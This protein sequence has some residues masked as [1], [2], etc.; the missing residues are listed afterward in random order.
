MAPINGVILAE[1]VLMQRHGF[2]LVEVMVALVILMVVLMGMAQLSA[3]M[4]HQVTTGGRQQAAVELAEG[5]IARIQA[6]PNYATLESLYVA[7]ETNFP[8]LAGFTRSTT[9]VRD[10]GDATR[11]HDWKRVTVKV[12]GPGLLAPVAR[13]IT[14]GAP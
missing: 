12:A 3:R 14:R 8:T 2:T 5:R 13:T 10:T 4:T 11:P 9:I 1:G 6:D 7:T